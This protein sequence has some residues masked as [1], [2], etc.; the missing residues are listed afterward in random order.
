MLTTKRRQ[1]CPVSWQVT[2][3]VPCLLAIVGES[4]LSSSKQRR[5]HAVYEQCAQSPGFASFE[6]RLSPDVRPRRFLSAWYMTHSG[7]GR[8]D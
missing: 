2:A 3:K 4:A 6:Y 5:K 1:K 8:V 7:L